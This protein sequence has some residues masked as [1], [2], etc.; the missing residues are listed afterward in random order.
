MKR[1]DGWNEITCCGGRNKKR[2]S[3]FD[4]ERSIVYAAYFRRN[5]L[6]ALA[7]KATLT[8]KDEIKRIRISKSVY[9]R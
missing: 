5:I 3:R 9:K 8:D 1:F 7:E 6:D 4:N 2:I